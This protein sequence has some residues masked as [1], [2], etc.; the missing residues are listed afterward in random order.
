MALFGLGLPVDKAEYDYLVPRRVD[1]PVLVVQGEHDEY[2]AGARVADLLAPVGTA[3][4]LRAHPGADHFFTDR[5]DELR[6]AVRGYYASG[7]GSR[8][9]AVL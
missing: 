2:G 7:P 1:K 4:H 9:L 8:L 5:L 6:T 3:H